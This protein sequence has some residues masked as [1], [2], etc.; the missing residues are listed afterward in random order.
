L[1]VETAISAVAQVALGDEQLVGPD[2]HAGETAGTKVHEQSGRTEG[3][4]WIA[5]ATVTNRAYRRIHRHLSVV[6]QGLSVE[7]CAAAIA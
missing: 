2:I 7:H 6:R 5:S 1:L 3:L 4:V